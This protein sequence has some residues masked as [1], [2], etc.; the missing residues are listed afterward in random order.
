MVT[1][2]KHRFQQAEILY[3]GWRY[4]DRFINLSG[5][6]KAGAP[7]REQTLEDVSFTYSDRR[8]GQTGML[9]KTV[10]L[11]SRRFTFSNGL[12]VAAFNSDTANVDLLSGLTRSFEKGSLHI[13]FHHRTIT[14]QGASTR[15]VTENTGR[16]E[17]RFTDGKLSGRSYIALSV[18]K[19]KP[20]RLSLFVNGKYE[21]T[22]QG[23]VELWV[24]LGRYESGRMNYWYG[25]LRNE[26]KI[27]ENLRMELK[28]ANSYRR[29]TDPAHT[30]VV[31]LGIRALL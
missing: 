21:T 6:S 27:L 19:D 11:L 29:G 30:L 13:D 7:R 9:F 8:A 22:L 3:S 15:S 14:Q 12:I 26:R 18:R 23:M 1:E 17:G 5:G 24:N 25:F 2:G 4:G 16:L 20:T 28:L 31:S 10:V